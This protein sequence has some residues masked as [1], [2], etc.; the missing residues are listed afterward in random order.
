MR[1]N[2]KVNASLLDKKSKIIIIST[3]V[4]SSLVTLLIFG[5]IASAFIESSVI[6]ENNEIRITGRYGERIPI[7]QLNEVFLSN[8]LPDITMRTNGI[9]A[10]R[11]NKGYFRSRDLGRIKLLLHSRSA[12][13]LYII[14]GYDDRHVILN[15]QDKER[16]LE[17]YEQLRVLVG[18]KCELD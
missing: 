1:K 12:P 17:V 8:E 2:E 16:T 10:G 13:F 3:I 18:N 6:V 15:F 4:A 11:I 9:S 5:F 7:P 14:H